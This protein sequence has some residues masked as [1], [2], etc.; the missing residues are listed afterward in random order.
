[1]K[2]KWSNIIFLLIV[3]LG[4]FLIPMTYDIN[5]KIIFNPTFILYFS[6]Y[7]ILTIISVCAGFHRLYSHKSYNSHF[8][9]DFFFLSMSSSI[10]NGKIKDWVLDHI[11]HHRYMDDPVKDPSSIKK[12]FIYSH[13]GWLFFDRDHNQKFIYDKKILWFYDK[14][15]LL[16]SFLFGLIVPFIIL[17]KIIPEL[18][19]INIF[20]FS[21]IVRI[22]I[23]HHAV[24]TL[25]SLNHFFGERIDKDYSARNNKFVNLLTLGDG[26]HFNHHKY[27]TTYRGGSP[28]IYVDLNRLF[29]EFCFLIGLA[30]KKNEK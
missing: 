6:V 8:L 1:M 2:K 21:I 29:I 22:F 15:V 13:I 24:F 28:S 9:L 7:Y 14:N 10:F 25:N 26:Y 3:N 11:D 18:N 4:F 27:D 5:Y 30:R 16:F 17:S 12:G 20:Y 23:I 19:L